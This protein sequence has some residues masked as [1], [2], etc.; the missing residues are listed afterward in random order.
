V[1]PVNGALQVSV[2]T[3][4][5]E[6]AWKFCGMPGAA[7]GVFPGP[8]APVTMATTS[9]EGALKPS[10]VTARTRMK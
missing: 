10:A 5:F 7:A 2:T 8:G 4:P 6:R 1:P 9:F 3:P